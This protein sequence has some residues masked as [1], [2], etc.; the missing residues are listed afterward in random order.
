M[1]HYYETENMPELEENMSKVGLP[2][3]LSGK[4]CTCNVGEAG[5]FLGSG[6]SPEEGNG[7][8]VIKVLKILL[9]NFGNRC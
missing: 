7:T 9:H 8:N 1:N 5:S 3:W 4:E 2:W 6:R